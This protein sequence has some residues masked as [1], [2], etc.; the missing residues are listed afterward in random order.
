MTTDA[1]GVYADT[2]FRDI[3]IGA[4]MRKGHPDIEPG[5]DH[6]VDTVKRLRR[7]LD[8]PLKV[9]DVGSGSGHLSWLLA[10]A[11]ED[12]EIIANEISSNSIAQAR[13]K[14]ASFRHTRIF[15]RS[16][17]DWNEPV[18]VFIS[19]GTHHHLSHSYLTQVTRL[20]NPGGVLIVGDEMCPEYL[21][22]ADQQR[23][24]AATTIEIV[25]GYIFDNPGDI[26]AYRESGVVPEWNLRLERARQRALW[27]WYKFVGDF[28]IERE[29]W[30]VLITELQIARDDLIT[31]FAEEHKTSPYLL[32]RELELNRFTILE[33]HAVGGADRPVSLQSF[34]IYTCRPEGGAAR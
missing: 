21:T 1:A 6:I 29:E 22:P 28:A 15:D 10:Q 12:G 32:Q 23:L 16:F 5:D 8:R 26:R 3:D 11:L 7:E 2:K 25:D 19:W 24:R 33:R 17:D 30:M 13:A 20:L 9:L 27:E 34:V 18:D 31:D 4:I 14:L